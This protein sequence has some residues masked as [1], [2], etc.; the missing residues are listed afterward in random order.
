MVPPRFTEATIVDAS[1]G[2]P[3]AATLT[4]LLATL[5]ALPATLRR[6]A[7]FLCWTRKEAYIKAR[8]EGLSLSLD[9]FDESLIPGEPAVLLRTRLDSDDAQRWA[10]QELSPELPGYAAALAVEGDGWSLA[11][12]QWAGSRSSSA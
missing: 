9:Q 5:R 10:L 8:G 4:A 6:Q 11:L 1:G 7:F 12:W 3:T 2:T